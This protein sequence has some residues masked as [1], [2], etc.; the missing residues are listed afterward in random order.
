MRL[1]KSGLVNVRIGIAISCLRQTAFHLGSRRLSFH[2]RDERLDI[3]GISLDRQPAVQSIE[4]VERF[5]GGTIG[6]TP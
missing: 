3:D 6:P 1:V 4:Q 5:T 2:L